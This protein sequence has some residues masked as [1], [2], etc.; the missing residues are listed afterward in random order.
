MLPATSTCKVKVNAALVQG[1]INKVNWSKRQNCQQAKKHFLN[2]IKDPDY[3]KDAIHRE[4]QKRKNVEKLVYMILK[5]KLD[6]L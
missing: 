5:L 1:N 3:G 6:Y 2:L 4:W